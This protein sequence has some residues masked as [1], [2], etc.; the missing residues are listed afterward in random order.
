MNGPV[1]FI[2]NLATGIALSQW[3]RRRAMFFL[4]L[5]A[6]LMLFLGTFV[7]WESFRGHP[8]FFVIYWFACGWLAICVILLAVY[9]L[10]MVLRSARKEHAAARRKI[11]KDLD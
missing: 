3:Q 11:F 10:L 9:D 7:I 2:L 1:R 6:I 5:T 4:T 8:I